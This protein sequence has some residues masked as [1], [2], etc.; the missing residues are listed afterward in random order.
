MVSAQTIDVD[1]QKKKTAASNFV[2]LNIIMT[3]CSDI[4]KII[5]DP[6]RESLTIDFKR[7]EMI[8]SKEG[9]KKLLEHIVSFANRNGGTIFLG[10]NDDATFEGKRF[11]VDKDKGTINNIIND[12]IRPVLTCDIERVYCKDGDVM[13]IYIPKMKEF[14]DNVH[15]ARDD[16]KICA[17][18]YH[19]GRYTFPQIIGRTPISSSATYS[20]FSKCTPREMNLEDI[21]REQ[22]AFADAALRAKKAGFDCVEICGSAGYLM[23]QFLSPYVNKRTD[24][25]GGDFENRLRFPLETIKTIKDT[26]GNDFVVGMRM[27]GDDFV[28][29]SLT[30]K[31]K[32][33]IFLV[34][35]NV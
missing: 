24:E 15:N 12:K 17:Q 8:S 34:K 18:L 2:V 11:D 30:Y 33:P 7:S 3:D 32:P 9:Q 23:D 25:Y 28:P 19:G 14:T 27:A 4:Q 22:Q 10:I 16:V 31:D 26:V 1:I 20:K 6:N 21:K 35:K 13:V 29:G 5:D